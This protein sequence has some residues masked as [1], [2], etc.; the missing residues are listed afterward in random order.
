MAT[1]ASHGG[2]ACAGEA[3]DPKEQL[4][5]LENYIMSLSLLYSDIF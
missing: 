4:P 2:V 1:Q 5:F 3:E